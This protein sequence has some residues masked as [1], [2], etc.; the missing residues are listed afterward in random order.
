MYNKFFCLLILYFCQ[1]PL[2]EY[3]LQ[4]NP[5][6]EQDPYHTSFM[7]DCP[8]ISNIITSFNNTW[9]AQHLHLL[10]QIIDICKAPYN[11]PASQVEFLHG[12]TT[13]TDQEGK[14]TYH[15]HKHVMEPWEE[16]QWYPHWPKMRACKL[17]QNYYTA[18]PEPVHCKHIYKCL[19]QLTF[20]KL[21]HAGRS[22]LMVQRKTI[23]K[24]CC[25]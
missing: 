9:P 7:Q 15:I 17:Y 23:P 19:F 8:I 6:N 18:V 4:G 3:F 14:V 22:I 24:Y 25:I 12:V 5:L 10:K 21:T 20:L 16:G 2:A 1:L 11:V 13:A